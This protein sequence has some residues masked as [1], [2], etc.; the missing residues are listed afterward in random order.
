[1]VMAARILQT[2]ALVVAALLP[3]ERL[4]AQTGFSPRGAPLQADVE[5]RLLESADSTSARTM[6]RDLSARPHMAGTRAQAR[7][8]DYVIARLQSWG[9]ETWVKEYTVY[10]PQPEVVRA[11]VLRRR[12]GQNMSLDLAEP[13]VPGD[14]ATTGPQVPPFNAY[15]GDGDVTAPAVYV[16]YGLARDYVTL[17]SLGV[18]LRGRI[19]IARYGRSF[20]GIKAREAER[21]GAIGLILY[22]D[23]QDD[24]YFHG[25]IYPRGPMRPP[26]GIQRGSVLN[27]NGD[28]TTPGWASTAQARRVPEESLTVPRI[29]VVPL[30]YGNAR[31]V[32]QRMTGP[33]APEGWQGGLPMH[34]HLGPGPVRVRLTVKTER[35][36]RALHPVWNTFARIPGAIHPDEWVVVGAHRDAWSPGAADNV[37]GTVTV[38]ETARAFADLA[39][40]GIPPARTLLFVTWDA[41]EW[42]LIGSTEWVEEL[43]DSVRSHV[44]AYLNEDDVASGIRFAG[45][46]SPSLKPLIRDVTRA[47]ADPDGRGTV[48][49]AWLASSS[50]DTAALRIDN[51]GGGSDFAAFSHHL[52]IPSASVGFGNSSGVYHS[53]YD[54][55]EWMSRFG[56]PGF[57]AHRAAAQLLSLTVAR[58]ANADILPFDF[59]ALG[60]ELTALARQ[61]DSAIARRGWR[62]SS[63]ALHASLAQ[64]TLA[65][66]EFAAVRDS[67]LAGGVTAARAA[68][69]NRCL[70]QVEQSFTRAQGLAGRP[71][72]RNLQFASDID[73]GY[74]TMA[75]PS[76]NEPIRDG[77]PA[78]VEREMGDFAD[79]VE[80]ARGAIE[81]AIAAL[82]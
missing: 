67:A 79:H 27:Q 25:D 12:D 57:R 22:S 3:C 36:G 11:W 62:V 10:L 65:A 28:P 8:R 61:A 50:G 82:R 13:A 63:A 7:T 41:E 6:T 17:D 14:P 2:A 71:W 49:D 29:P 68:Q 4:R 32:L 39:R 45:S 59:V 60:T 35:G 23:P 30:G 5:Q 46:A 58:L 21:H 42:G 37:S 16:N 44:V 75:L 66:R 38:L 33:S 80:Q 48:Y 18:R 53:M 24:G 26:G 56:D 43:E 78:S 69:T 72:Y 81:R 64:F 47:V 54:S 76:I 1:M 73:N 77:D 34:Y 20:R 51:L 52:G 15:T 9:L 40:A 74:S 31:R 19:A 55:F 70:V